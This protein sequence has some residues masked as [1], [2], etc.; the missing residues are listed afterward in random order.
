MHLGNYVGAIQHFVELAKD[1]RNRC[2]YFIANYHTLT[3]LT[4]PELLR[5]SLR[6]I[7]LDYMS[8]GLD[9]DVATI[10]AQSSVPE[11]TE[12]TWIISNLTSVNS[13]V[14]MPHFKEKR[15]GLGQSEMMANSG[16]LFYPVLMA[17]D[18]LCVKANLVPVGQDQHPH[19]EMT[20]D[21]AKK[22]NNLYG[23]LFP[24]PNLLE[25]EGLRLPGLTGEGKMSK[26]EEDEGGVIYLSDSPD[27]VKNKIR[28]GVTDK[29]RKRRSDPGNPEDCSIFTYHHVFSTPEEIS[30]TNSGC[31]NAEIGC[32]ECKDVIIRHVNDILEPMQQKRSELEALGKGFIDDVVHNGGR[33]ARRI[34]QG[35]VRE[36]KELVGVPMY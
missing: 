17:A 14:S 10:Y 21:I 30:W 27:T 34:I 13:L 12:L 16:L 26:S 25:G 22:F 35:T 31:R 33:R 29:R 32:V 1:D 2:F 5:N 23:N 6:G 9:P 28:K 24:V 18:I 3:T 19:V 11:I 7:I 8:A 20:R 15:E 4:D 36:A